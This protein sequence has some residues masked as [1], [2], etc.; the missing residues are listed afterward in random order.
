MTTAS[1]KVHQP[2]CKLCLRGHPRSAPIAIAAATMAAATQS[3]VAQNGGHHR[4]FATNRVRCCQ[5]SLTSR[6]RKPRALRRRS[7]I[8]PLTASVP[9]LLA[10]LVSKVAEER[11]PP[12]LQGAPEPCDLRDRTGRQAGEHGL[13][14]TSSG[15][16]GVLVEAGADLLGA[17]VGRLDLTCSSR[18]VNAVRNRPAGGR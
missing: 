18:A 12:S 5:K 17:A 6:L 4:V 14:E 2:F 15:R 16:E 11:L 1:A 9:P 7:S 10:P 13:G 3:V 8:R